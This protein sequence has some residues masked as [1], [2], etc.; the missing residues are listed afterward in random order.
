MSDAPK[1]DSSVVTEESV[2]N[3]GGNLADIQENLKQEL[4]KAKIRQENLEKQLAELTRENRH[5]L[6]RIRGYQTLSKSFKSISFLVIQET[7]MRN[8]KYFR[9]LTVLFKSIQI[10]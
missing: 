2:V 1:T 5:L 10:Y 8:S 9:L 3:L 7:E 6:A 4:F